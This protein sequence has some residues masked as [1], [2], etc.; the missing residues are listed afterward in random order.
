MVV[1]AALPHW[2]P[3]ACVCLVLATLSAVLVRGH[4]RSWAKRQTEEFSDP[5]DLL[6]YQNQH[7]RRL[8]TSI[9]IGL[10]GILIFVGDLISEQ[11][12]PGKFAIYWIGVLLLVGY[13]VTLALLDALATATHMKASLARLR[14]QRRQ[15]E[16]QAA[17]MKERPQTSDFS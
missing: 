12:G 8:Q 9:L 5:A 1:V 15:I 17:E 10:I 14:A 11:I 13:L 2:T 4:L 7:R 16:R 6:H 3:S